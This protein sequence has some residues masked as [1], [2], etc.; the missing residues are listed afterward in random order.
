MNPTTELLETIEIDGVTYRRETDYSNDS[1][2]RFAN[3]I[4]AIEKALKWELEWAVW[5]IMYVDAM[6][7]NLKP[8][9]R[10]SLLPLPYPPN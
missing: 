7:H 10:N 1:A 2:V 6:E 3:R 8:F 5:A 4:T 9:N